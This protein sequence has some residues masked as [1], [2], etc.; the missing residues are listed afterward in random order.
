MLLKGVK[1]SAL[2]FLA[3]LLMSVQNQTNKTFA[4]DPQE[5]LE[6]QINENKQSID[7][8]KLQLEN[9]EKEFKDKVIDKQ[10]FENK[11]KEIVAEIKE[12][13][14]LNNIE[15]GNVES[16]KDM[17]LTDDVLYTGT[18]ETGVDADASTAE[19]ELEYIDERNEGLLE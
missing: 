17:E 12:M 10:T 15:G 9:L 19:S 11:K 6:T 3:L 5:V 16:K 1:I 2:I 18:D 14:E 13:E 8:L 7:E 4:I